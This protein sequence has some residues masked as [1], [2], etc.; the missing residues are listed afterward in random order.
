MKVLHP[1][2]LGTTGLVVSG[3]GLGTNNFGTR[4][5]AAASHA[6]LSAALDAGINLIDTADVYGAG[7][8]ERII[9]SWL[10]TRRD[11]VVLATKV[12][13]DQEVG[14]TRIGSSA[15]HIKR[16]VDESLARL[17][18]DRIDL[19]QLHIGDPLAPIDETLR[20]VDDLVRLGK[21]AYVGVSNYAAWEVV[22]AAERSRAAGWSPIVSV[23][24]EYSLLNRRV[25]DELLPAC[26][27]YGISLLPYRPLARGL[28][29]GKYRPAEPVPP[30]TRFALQ[31]AVGD[32][33]LT[34][35]NF[36]A[37]AELEAFAA[38]RGM[39]LIGLSLAW[40]LAQP[41][42]ASVLMGASSPDQLSSNVA[43]ASNV[44]SDAD[45]DALD[46]VVPPPVRSDLGQAALRRPVP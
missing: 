40:L 1:R 17:Q 5:D 14:G 6:V 16:G 2:Q 28:L 46:E 38:A 7:A 20:A 8:T 39:P 19:L 10:R 22:R 26:A 33:Y 21:V 34:G 4:L 9:G 45:L 23:Q 30:G 18:T 37:V 25:E 44:L 15:L 41:Q 35:P 12:G 42:V 24:P 3:L 43:A 32:Q 27:A 11:D 13:M 29:T 36:A 31:P